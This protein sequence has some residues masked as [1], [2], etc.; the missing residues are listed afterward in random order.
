MQIASEGNA[1]A[2]VRTAEAI[3]LNV[4]FAS[5]TPTDFQELRCWSEERTIA[6]TP[7]NGSSLKITYQDFTED[8]GEE[9][10]IHLFLSRVFTEAESHSPTLLVAPGKSISMTELWH[11]TRNRKKP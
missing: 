7:K 9:Y 6:I 3:S 2:M 11:I 8:M 1:V 4:D 10:P 5:S